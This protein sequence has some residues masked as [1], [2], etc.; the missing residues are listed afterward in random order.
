MKCDV[1]SHDP[2][3]RYLPVL[4]AQQQ[5]GLYLIDCGYTSI[6]PGTP[7]PPQ[8]HPDAYHFE[9]KTGRT[10]NEYQVVY[11]TQ[12]RGI[13]EARGVKRQTVEAG[14]LFILFP[15]VWH[16]YA[17]S[18]KTGWD[19]HWFG[20]N[21]DLA[22]RFLS[23]S[24]VPRTKPVLRVGVDE[25]LRRRFVG[26]VDDM[27][28]D[29]TGAPFSITGDLIKILGMIQERLQ[30]VGA[31]GRMSGVIREAQ[32]LILRQAT[33][34]IDFKKMAR[35]L[36]IGYSSFR[37]RF[38]QQT[39]VSP[40]QFQS[41]IRINRAKDLLTAT[42][43]SVSEIAEACGYK[44]VFYFSRQFTLKTGLTPSAHRANSLR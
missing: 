21:G 22:K 7:Y 6:P 1:F 15:G 5:W 12:G 27:M 16:R 4:P 37:H 11:I 42:D 40:A 17:P 34:Q 38:K 2:P 30:C 3:F 18:P 28:R 36:G 32:N 13:F 14:D 43:L 9:W 24:F 8:R 26:L 25:G 19:E 33:E 23:E 20:F 29:P 31:K 44:T 35:Q 39:G 10:L 41:S